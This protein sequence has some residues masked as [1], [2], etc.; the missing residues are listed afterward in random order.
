VRR[1]HD[2]DIIIV[3]SGYKGPDKQKLDAALAA[4]THS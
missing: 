2:G 3:A 1:V 4:V